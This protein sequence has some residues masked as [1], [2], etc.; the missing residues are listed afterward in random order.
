MKQFLRKHIYETIRDQIIYGK[1][2]PGERLTES[3]LVATFNSSRSPIREA[4]RQLESEGLIMAERNKGITVAKLSLEEAE[5]LYSLRWLLESY[6]ARLTAEKATIEDVK[7][8]KSL[9]IKLKEA[10]KKND[11]EMW[12]RNNTLF[13]DYLE[14]HCGNSNMI[15]I[16]K[17]L[18][19]RMYSYKYTIIRIPGHF[20]EYI[21]QHNGILRAC[22]ERDGELAEKC[23]RQHMATIKETIIG[24]L[25][26]YAEAPSERK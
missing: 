7:L 23:M 11:L 21:E 25:K 4:L 14:K 18:K 6:A 5:E 22:S 10:V 17:T 19:H 12:V 9:Q 24:Y 15:P 3:S 1:L 16:L 20:E 13:H 8:L 26:E 2:N